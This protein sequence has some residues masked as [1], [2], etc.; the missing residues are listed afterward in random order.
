MAE[1]H[2]RNQL[3]H[4]RETLLAALGRAEDFD[5]AYDAHRDQGQVS[6]RL[7]YL[8]GVWSNLESVQAQLEDIEITDEGRT[9]HAAVRAEFEPRLFTIKASL[10]SK[11]SPIPTDRSPVPPHVSSTLSGIKLPTI[12]LPEF[13]GDYMQWLAFHDT[14]LALIHSNPDVPDIQ[15]F[16][17]LRAA[18]KGEAA[19]LIESIGISSANYLLAWQTLENR[20][21]NDYLLRKRHLQALFDIPRMKKES[22]ASLHGLVDEFERHTKILHQLGEPT[23][24]WSSILEHLLCMRLHDDTLKAWEDHASTVA[25][26]DYAC[27]IDFLQRRARVLESISVNH[28]STESASS[29]GSSSHTL[30][31]NHFHSQFRL[32]SCASTAGS[33]EKCIACS[34]SHSLV[35][36]QKFIRLSTNER[37]QFVISKRLCHNCLKIGHF[38]RNCPSKFSCRKCNSRHHTLL[39]FGQ[40]DSSPRSNREGIS[41][42]ASATASGTPSSGPSTSE[43]STQLTVAATEDTPVIEVSSTL[44]YPREDVFLLTVVVKVVDAFGVEHLARALLDSA[45]QPNLITNRMTQI[46]RLRRQH[47]NITVQGAGKLSKPVRE[48]V[49]AQIFSR[50]GDFSCGVNFLVMENVTANLPSQN[51]ST[52]GWKI[53]KELFLAD[54]AFNKSQPI[55]MVLGA[56]HFY[57][58]FPSAARIQLDSNLPL[59]VDSVFGWIIAGSANSYSNDQITTSS[60]S[61]DAAVVSMISLEDCLEKF[62]KTE[63]LANNDSYSV[64]ERHCESLYQSTV[65]R[66]PEGRYVVRYPRK[67]DFDAM[68]GESRSNAQR[69]FEYLE[70]RLERNPHLR[71]DYHQFM[72]EYLALG[73]MRLVVKDDE[74]N[75]QVYYLPHHPVIKEASST[76]K[77]RVVFDGS[78]KTSTG[79]S[80][81]EALCVGPVVQ[82]DL[83]NIILRFRTFPI[84]LV[85]DNAKMYRQAL[86]HSDDTPLQR[87]LWRFSKQCPVQTYELLTVTYGLGP[88]SFLATRTLHQLA[89]DEGDQ[90]SVGSQALRKG[91]YVDDFIGGAETV[92]EAILLRSELNDLLQKGGFELRKWTSNR[93]EVLKGL[94]DDQIGT[95]S[96]LHFSPHETIKALGISWEPEADCLRFDSQIR[97]NPVLPTKR[98]ILSDIAKLFDPLGLI[99]P[100]I[101]RAKILMQELWLLSCGWDDPVPEPI[102]S[103]WENYHR[104][105]TKISKHRI[106]RY[107][108]L[109]GSDIQLHTFADA[110]QAAYGACTY[111]RC[112]NSQGIVRIQL[113]ASKS[114][115]APLKRITIARLEL[116]AAVLA[117]H[118]HARIKNAIDVNVCTSYFWS[119]SAV[120]LQ[121]PPNVWPTFVA[122]RVSEIQQFTHGCQWKHV[123]GIENPADLVSRG[124]SVDDFLKSALWKCGPSWLPSPPQDWPISIPLGVTADDLELKTTVAVTQTTSTIHPWFLRWSSYSRLLHVIGYCLRFIANT[125]SKS[126]TQ[127]SQSFSSLGQSL[128]VAELAKSK[129]VLTRLAQHDGYAAEIKQLEKGN[130]VS[131]QSNIRQMNP[132]IDQERVLRVGGR[133]NLAQLPYQAKH[134]SLI[135]NNHPFTRLIAEHFHRKLLHGGG[136]LLISAIREEFWPPNGRRLVHSIVRNCFRCNRVN[137]IPAQQQIGQL[138]VQRVIPSR[139]FSITGV[140]YAGPLYLRP[141][142][143]RASPAKTYL[144]LFVCFST[145]AVH[146]EL[147]SDLST[148]AFLCSLRR[149]IAR[150]G[151]P[152]H[153]HSDNGKNF[154]GA[155]NELIE[156]FARF[157][158]RSEQAEIISACAEQGITWHLT[159]PKAPHFGGLWEAAIKVA[160]KH[161]YRQLGSSRLTFEDMCTVLAQI[162]AIMNSRP[163]LPLTE[164]PNDLA[165]LTPAHFLIGSSLHALPD[166]DLQSIPANRLDHYQQLQVHV[167]RFWT[168][169]KKEYLQELLK[170][171]RGW[172]R[173]DNIIPG[174]LVIVVDELQPPIR[175]PLARIESILPGRDQLTRVVQLRTARGII[176]RPIAKICMLPD[177]T[178]VPASEKSPVNNN[179]ASTIQRSSDTTLV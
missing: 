170:D 32:T 65:S 73:H 15:K 42:S 72:R 161:L 2:S 53:P 51:I 46:L 177:S 11:L 122:N 57:S 135:P 114:R 24:T 10:M 19:Q 138:P 60:T 12:S 159:P 85:G 162:E 174:K 150:R 50:K 104:E 90:H 29:S 56:R 169:W 129:T 153:I 140:D 110:S 63:E 156:L 143:K 95:Q 69:R 31:R 67:P 26:P 173:N 136:R 54:P 76:T 99:A 64:E 108:L 92:E 22:A 160:K 157:K 80:L 91:F 142:H 68:L 49:F 88:S 71:D 127:P 112:V 151:C 163:L 81:N 70:K 102:K 168:H 132:F 43:L 158:N 58:F 59:L 123:S 20:Y 66:N 154:E 111:A 30:K 6:L 178:T 9:E 35:K 101:V 14:F 117:A 27:I 106:D 13:D 36:C 149:F 96:T 7:E 77:L 103:K 152:A 172:Q 171:T 146:L 98:S 1:E 82:E 84:A 87:I 115:V 118:L 89:D 17:Y 25:N 52:E 37:Q 38:V 167:Q 23:D 75:S 116:C 83:L 39:H 120:T 166:P 48:S 119:D 130:S 126:R 61:C 133:L 94:N 105:L 179:D 100:V 124:M 4:R 18:I 131:K 5:A 74:R 107:A 45:S 134:P 41:S 8:N 164:D 137:P 109:P 128:T 139:P 16:H 165:A 3:L 33:G 121:S 40:P 141:I 79:F 93:L 97:T 147:V 47:V 86:V 144:C 145:K 34:Q 62:W 113:L 44:Q 55:D 125:R 78:A 21:S 155:K 176:T 175:W 148:Q 28:H